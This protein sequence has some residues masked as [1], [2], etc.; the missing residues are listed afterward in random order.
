MQDIQNKLKGKKLSH[1]KLTENP[2]Y[3]L[4]TVEDLIRHNSNIITFITC[5]RQFVDPVS[6]PISRCLEIVKLK[7]AKEKKRP[8]R[9]TTELVNDL[10]KAAA[11]CKASQ[12]TD[13]QFR[14]ALKLQD[15]YAKLNP[16]KRNHQKLVENPLYHLE[17]V[18]DVIRYNLSIIML[19]TGIPQNSGLKSQV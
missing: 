10:L 12:D 6:T 14:L 17:K 15:I 9:L 8:M 19:I 1:Q 5:T 3:Y 7:A 4:E 11:E 18:E 13:C 2:L 16:P